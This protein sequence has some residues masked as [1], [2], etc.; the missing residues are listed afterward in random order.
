M[1]RRSMASLTT[2]KAGLAVSSAALERAKFMFDLNGYYIVR[3]VLTEDEVS[4]ANAAIDK[5]GK[6][7]QP[8]K[9]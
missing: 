9:S 5:H 7:I 1:I 8:R 2:S 4:Q 6:S 3:G